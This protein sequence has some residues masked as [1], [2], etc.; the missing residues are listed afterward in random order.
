MEEEEEADEGDEGPSE[1]IFRGKIDGSV[2]DGIP[3]ADFP[4]GI[5]AE[6]KG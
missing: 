5:S 3:S 4:S 6:L 2:S 1:S